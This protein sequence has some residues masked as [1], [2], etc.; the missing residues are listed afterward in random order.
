MAAC[1]DSSHGYLPRS[2]EYILESKERV[3]DV[4]LVEVTCASVNGKRTLSNENPVKVILDDP[5]M[6]KVVA[7]SA[8]ISSVLFPTPTMW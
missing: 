1:A 3:D 2:T 6:T 8:A 5:W 4:P 7:M